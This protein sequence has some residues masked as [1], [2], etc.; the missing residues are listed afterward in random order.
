[1][2][3]IGGWDSGSLIKVWEQNIWTTKL[4]EI[5]IPN[6]LHHSLLPSQAEIPPFLSSEGDKALPRGLEFGKFQ[7]PSSK[8]FVESGGLIILRNDPF[9]S[10]PFPIFGRRKAGKS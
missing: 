8:L 2:D 9:G 1:M 5:K 3:P 6:A 10:Y 7:P 4:P